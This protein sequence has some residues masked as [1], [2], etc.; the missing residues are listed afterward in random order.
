M[1]IILILIRLINVN[2]KIESNQP[3]ILVQCKCFFFPK[4]KLENSI[5]HSHISPLEIGKQAK[6]ESKVINNSFI[7]MFRSTS[8][9]P[10]PL[11]NGLLLSRTHTHYAML[12]CPVCWVH[13]SRS[14][15]GY[16]SE[17]KTPRPRGALCPHCTRETDYHM[18]YYGY[19]GRCIYINSHI[20]PPIVQFYL[21][22]ST[23]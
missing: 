16:H 11:S 12:R 3:D 13:E 18:V 22:L 4:M 15:S 8:P 23:P 9:P 5:S 19:V 1:N 20:P 10:Q 17:K 14:L 7:V 2:L 6:W 21:S